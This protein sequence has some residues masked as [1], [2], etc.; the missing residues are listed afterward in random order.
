MIAFILAGIIAVWAVAVHGQMPVIDWQASSSAIYRDSVI[1][2]QSDDGSA[3]S[4]VSIGDGIVLTAAHVIDNARSVTITCKEGRFTG[5]P[6]ISLYGDLGAILLSRSLRVP[7][8]KVAPGDLTLGQTVYAAGYD[9]G[10][11]Y[12][13]FRGTI[14]HWSIVENGK[15]AWSGPAGAISGNSGGPVFNDRGELVGIISGSMEVSSEGG[16]TSW[17]HLTTI[18]NFLGRLK[19]RRLCPPGTQPCPPGDSQPNA[20]DVYPLPGQPSPLP[21]PMPADPI[22]GPPGPP[23]RDG[24]DGVDGRTPT[25]AELVALIRQSIDYD[26]LAEVVVTKY[27]DQLKGEKGDTGPAGESAP[28]DEI[29]AAVIAAFP[30]R[31]VVVFDSGHSPPKKIDDETYKPGEAMVFDVQ[32]IFNAAR[33]SQ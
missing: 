20:P 18:R 11:R 9:F 19:Q 16:G 3:G 1:H 8:V 32:R 2:V 5:T 14:Q 23:G 27:G 21:D 22:A 4:G 6:T 26:K 17:V 30:P 12:R 29:V 10:T 15:H 7:Q 31:R 33:R 28:M 25:E 24:R 13:V